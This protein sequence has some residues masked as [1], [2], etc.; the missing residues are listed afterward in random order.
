MAMTSGGNL[1][2]FKWPPKAFLH[3][4]AVKLFED[5][6]AATDRA[7]IQSEG[8]GGTVE[9]WLNHNARERG[10]DGWPAFVRACK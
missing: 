4:T 5:Y 9:F 1:M 2:S 6:D 10:F 7:C 8:E 3:H